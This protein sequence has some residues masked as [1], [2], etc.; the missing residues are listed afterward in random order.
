MLRRLHMLLLGA[1][2]L[3][4]PLSG[5]AQNL[6]D[7]R[8]NIDVKNRRAEDALDIIGKR[9]GFSFAYNSNI[10]SRDS[11]VTLSYTATPVRQLLQAMF[12]DRYQYKEMDK[13][14]VI[15][16]GET[17]KWFT[18]SGHIS[19]AV[20]GEKIEHASIIETK[21]LY[22]TL[23]DANGYFRLRIK[24]RGKYMLEEVKVSKGTFYIDTTLNLF[25]GY[26]QEIA[27]ALAPASYNIPDVVVTQ[28]GMEH[29]WFGKFLISSKL[30][31]QSANLSKFFVDKPV[32]AS[33]I[34]GVGTHG[35]LSSQVT[36]KFSFNLLGG[37]TAGVDGFELGGLFN[38]D[39]KDVKYAQVGGVFNIVSGNVQGA[40]IGGVFN[41]VSGS[42]RGGEVGGVGN[43]VRDS[44]KG[45]QI[46]GVFN[47]TGGHVK[48]AQIAGIINLQDRKDTSGSSTADTF[49]EIKGAQVAGIANVVNND[50][51]GAQVAGITNIVSKSVHGAQ[52]AGIINLVNE[53]VRGAQL[54][55]IG[56]VARRSMKGVQVSGIFNIGGRVEG[57]Q[58]A[59]INIA[60]TITGYGIGLVNVVRKGYHAIA[61]STNDLTDFTL[62]YKTGTK[63]LYN[64]ISVGM[65]INGGKSDFLYG[66][67]LGAEQALSKHIGLSL[68]CF[69]GNLYKHS[70]DANALLVR[71]EPAF[72]WNITRKFTLYTGPSLSLIPYVFYGEGNNT[73]S[74]DITN[75]ALHDFGAKNNTA[76]WIGWQVGLHIF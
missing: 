57:S 29:S 32:Q 46:G 52:V 23:S 76:A 8:I 66:F 73:T 14:V 31:Q 47:R 40:Q 22:S 27:I 50:V 59:L 5:F 39:K 37:Y 60:D 33:I 45:V 20:T 16:P 71:I 53:D 65:K 36:N 19:D 72:N 24:D 26:D 70:L 12:G 41:N 18:I 1:I 58:I 55:G 25:P 44:V 35:K 62:S 61:L 51:R 75:M 38:I 28:Y 42:V 64:V 63:R 9:A 43:I 74:Y 68:E 34:P 21:S 69:A 56:N 54:S 3:L 11:L 48:G 6:L 2:L 13:H 7:K 17:E 30:R 10:I 49:Y 67:G 15:L 4:A